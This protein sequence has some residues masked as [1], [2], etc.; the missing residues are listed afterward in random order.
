[1]AGVQSHSNEVRGRRGV[2]RGRGVLAILTILALWI[3][4]GFVR[5]PA[6]ARDY[7]TSRQ[8]TGAQLLNLEANL[9]P[10]IPPF[11]GVEIHGEVVEAGQHPPGYV[12]AMILWIEPLTG[13]VI[14]MG[15]G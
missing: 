7:W 14:V 3:V 15:A 10:A 11:W 1:M 2:R 8:G 5:A 12:S 4:L 6:V 9:Q 13:W